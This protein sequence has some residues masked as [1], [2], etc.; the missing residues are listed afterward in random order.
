M[1]FQKKD[2]VR[3]LPEFI[4]LYDGMGLKNILNNAIKHKV[5]GKNPSKVG[6]ITALGEDYAQVDFW[7][8]TPNKFTIKIT[9]LE[10]VKKADNPDEQGIGAI[11]TEE[12]AVS[13]LVEAGLLE[14][15]EY[16]SEL[17]KRKEAADF[18]TGKEPKVTSA[19]EEA[20]LRPGAAMAGLP[21]PVKEN[22]ALQV[23][24][25]GSHYKDLAI[26][27]IEYITKNNLSFGQGN[28]IKYIT[29]YKNKN[30]LEDLEKAKHMIELMINLEY[31]NN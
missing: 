29:R 20:H 6:R 30:G 31:K 22:N 9:H 1:N 18:I 15:D 3:I 4:D 28:V 13:K 2:E 23:Q 14:E 12:D 11:I 10:L 25:G 19:Y 27:P 17:V 16:E 7:N 21:I 26:Q 24:K 8:S 5:T